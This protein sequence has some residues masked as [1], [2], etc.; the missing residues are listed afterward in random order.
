MRN[1]HVIAA[2]ALVYALSPALLATSFALAPAI[3]TLAGV[4]ASLFIIARN[5]WGEVLQRPVERRWLA[6]CLVLAL[7]LSMLGGQGH[8]FFAKDDWLYRD[9]VLSDIAAHWLPVFYQDGDARYMLRAP[10]GMYLAPSGLG[11]LFGLGAAHLALLTQSGVLLG[12]FFYAATLAFERRRLLFL[13]L[14]VL[15]SGLDVLPVLI[16]TGGENILVYLAFWVDDW[17]YPSNLTQLF[18]NPNHVLPGWWFAALCVLHLRREID[19]ATL[20]AASLP[21]V[22]WSPL[23]LFGAIALFVFLASRELRAL[24]SWRFA[25]VLATT[26]GF[27]PT[28]AYLVADAGEVPHKWLVFQPSFLDFYPI[29]I[30]FALT[31]IA[32]VAAFRAR[33]APWFAGALW[34]SVLLLLLIP[35]YDLGFM[36]DF[37]MRA[38]IVPRALLA[39]GFNALLIELLA[40]GALLAAAAGALIASIGAVTPALEIYDSISTPAFRPSDCNLATVHKKLHP[41]DFLSTYL[42]RPESFPGFLMHAGQTNAPFAASARDCWPDRKYGEKLFNWL[43]PENR[44]WLRGPGRETPDTA[45]K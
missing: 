36:K 13:A 11:R 19:L 23:A 21:L 20:A 27:V 10:L 9:A 18:W 8:F 39:F 26:L 2:A 5:P 37:S 14:F 17:N 45:G 24:W 4:L 33:I 16:K 25:S 15:F 29:F 41:R 42:A 7:L 35:V 12:A 1:F 31:Q 6:I 40:Q 38:P 3:A 28:L 32:F 22:L 43:K 44:I 34:F 30:L